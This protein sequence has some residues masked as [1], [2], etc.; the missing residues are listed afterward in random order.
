MTSQHKKYDSFLNVQNS[1]ELPS[2]LLSLK[3][4]GLEIEEQE[5]PKTIT[6]FN[7]THQRYFNSVEPE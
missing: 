1:L 4:R 7:Q 3:R 5:V 2:N 6:T